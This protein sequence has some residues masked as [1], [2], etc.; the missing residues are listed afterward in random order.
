MIKH[1]VSELSI[2][3]SFRIRINFAIADKE[4]SLISCLAQNRFAAAQ[5]IHC[6]SAT[7]NCH[8]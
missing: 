1:R 2:A 6:L 5:L 4:A 7:F 3:E 8:D